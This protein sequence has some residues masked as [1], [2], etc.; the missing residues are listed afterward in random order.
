MARHVTKPFTHHGDLQLTRGGG[1]RAQR[2][3]ALSTHAVAI[4]P[5]VAGDLAQARHLALAADEGA[6]QG[7]LLSLMPTI[8]Q[9]DRDDLMMRGCWPSSA[10]SIWSERHTTG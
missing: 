8:E 1:G 7:L 3:A 2:A 4:D 5:G 9:A 10:G 6:A